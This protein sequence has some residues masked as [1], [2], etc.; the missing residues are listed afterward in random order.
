M[1][2]CHVSYRIKLI[3]FLGTHRFIV[4]VNLSVKLL[5]SVILS[6]VKSKRD[7]EFEDYY[8]MVTSLLEKKVNKERKTL[9]LE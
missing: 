5:I 4:H 1:H 9:K 3:K 6:T 7:Y 8:N 2:H